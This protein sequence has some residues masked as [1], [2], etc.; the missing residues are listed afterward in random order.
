M[1]GTA[2]ASFSV[3]GFGINGIEKINYNDIINRVDFINNL[4]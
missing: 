1:Y 2:T 4:L 3:E